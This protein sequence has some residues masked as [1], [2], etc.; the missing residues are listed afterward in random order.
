MTGLD[1]ATI[2]TVAAYTGFRA[3]ELSGLTPECFGERG[4]MFGVGRSGADTKNGKAALQFLPAD[5]AAELRAYL[6]GRAA[7]V[8]LWDSTWF[9]RGADMIRD[10]AKAA[11]IELDVRTPVGVEVLDVHS[12]RGTLATMLD[13]ADVPLKVRQTILRH[14]DPRL[15]TNRYTKTTAAAVGGAITALPS[16]FASPDRVPVPYTELAQEPDVGRNRSGA[17][18]GP[19]PAL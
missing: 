18:E 17:I 9:Q 7:G 10:D 12:L 11:G 15:T 13:T 16:V 4:G 3:E 14:S 6:T 1:R 8:R 5:V 19:P 2:Y